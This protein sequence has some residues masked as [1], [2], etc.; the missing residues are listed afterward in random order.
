M[1][2]SPQKQAQKQWYLVEYQ[3]VAPVVVKL[4]V[5]AENEEDAFSIA[6]TNRAQ[7]Y[8]EEKPRVDDKFM[9]KKKVSVKNLLT[10]IVGFIK[11]F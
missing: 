9:V 3:G 8:L 5:L 10:G 4:R 1:P 7:T 6:E 2:S 11:N